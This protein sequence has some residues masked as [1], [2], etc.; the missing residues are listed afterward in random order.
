[1]SSQVSGK[2]TQSR[3]EGP[4]ELITN[5]RTYVARQYDAGKL[6]AVEFGVVLAALGIDESAKITENP[7]ILPHIGIH[8]IG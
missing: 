8:G 7:L 2:R 5:A 6:S 3:F 1:M 4:A